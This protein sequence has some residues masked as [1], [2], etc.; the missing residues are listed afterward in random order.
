MDDQTAFRNH[1][2]VNEGQDDSDLRFRTH[3]PAPYRAGVLTLGLLTTAAVVIALS[4][5]LSIAMTLVLTISLAALFI[6]ASLMQ[7]V[8]RLSLHEIH[9]RVAG[10]FRTTIP[11]DQIVGVT[12]DRN[13]GLRE[14]MGLR[15]LPRRTAGYLVGGSSVRI[16]TKRGNAVLI[17]S[18]TPKELA[19][20]I[21]S[22]L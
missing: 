21:D 7:T 1:G 14:G 6:V 11:Y 3:M 20:A 17:S 9:V 19:K 15:I 18:S 22:R 13:T 12:P 10:I 2:V 8:V 16:E 5:E 4:A